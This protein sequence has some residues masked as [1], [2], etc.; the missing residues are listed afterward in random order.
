MVL[1]GLPG[2]AFAA[3]ATSADDLA[4]KLSPANN[5]GYATWW[6]AIPSNSTYQNWF[7]TDIVPKQ[8]NNCRTD[9][10]T[11]FWNQAVQDNWASVPNIGGWAW[12]SGGYFAQYLWLRA[13]PDGVAPVANIGGWIAPTGG[14]YLQNFWLHAVPENWA[15]RSRVSGWPWS[16]GGYYNM[17]LWLAAV[18]NNWAT[19]PNIGGWNWATGGFY[20]Q[21]FWL[22]SVPKELVKV[23]NIGG[24]DK[25]TG[26]WYAQWFWNAAVP[27]NWASRTSLAGWPWKTGGYYTEWLWLHAVVDPWAVVPNIGGWNQATDGFYQ[28]F[29]FLRAVPGNI[30]P[31]PA[32][33][34]WA[35]AANAGYYNQWTLA[36]AI[37]EN[38]ASVPN[39]GSWPWDNG[40]FYAQEFWLE[41]VPDGVA[42]TTAQPSGYY[43][44]MLWS[45]LVPKQWLRSPGYDVGGVGNSGYYYQWLYRFGGSEGIAPRANAALFGD[46]NAGYYA[47]QFQTRHNTDAGI[48]PLWQLATGYL[49]NAKTARPVNQWYQP[50][51]HAVV[52]FAFDSEGS[53]DQSCGVADAFQK[54]DL[55][56]KATFFTVGFSIDGL[57]PCITDYDV[58]NHSLDHPPTNNDPWGVRSLFDTYTDADQQAEIQVNDARLTAAIPGLNPT[59]WRTPWCD[60]FKSF[61][62]S[63]AHNLLASGYQSDSSVPVFMPAAAGKTALPAY[64]RN[65]SAGAN[66]SPFIARTEGGKNLVEFPFA[67]PSDY[68]AFSFGLDYN[69]ADPSGTKADYAVNVWKKVFDEIYAAHGTMVFVMHPWLQVGDDGQAAAVDD[70]LTYMQ[71]KPGTYF[72]DFTEAR[73]KLH[74][75]YGW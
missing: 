74:T 19:R 61:D 43:D 40:G 24:W 26:G 31:V 68:M 73:A 57:A 15:S 27:D 30:H 28:Q 17:W 6:N 51:A 44:G 45:T 70:L 20:T 50:D 29:F 62:S 55:V 36:H 66:P 9:V 33:S 71:A 37:P 67:Y 16:T 4:C 52:M 32:I 11:T 3:A 49:A 38:W 42:P 18:P 54:H 7:W 48:A 75:A 58:Q 69:S 14:Y 34:G 60:S 63:V 22:V 23:P 5:P 53:A 47:Y 65:F 72:S 1:S 39:F 12:G 25:A 59:A 8:T 35:G 13:I 64:M 56:G 41:V 2:T 10:A 46:A 21:F